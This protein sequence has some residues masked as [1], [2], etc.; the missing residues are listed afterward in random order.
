MNHHHYHHHPNHHHHYH[1]AFMHTSS[2][3]VEAEDRRDTWMDDAETCLRCI[4]PSCLSACL[5]CSV[6]PTDTS[7]TYTHSQ[8]HT[9]ASLS[10]THLL[11]HSLTYSLSHDPPSIGTARAI[12]S[13]AL[14][15]FPT[16]KQL[17]HQ[18]AVL[19]VLY[20]CMYRLMDVCMCRWI[21]G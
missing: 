7:Y 9:H 3:G 1:H 14:S 19:E 5:P 6:S 2:I 21:D 10:L 17:W 4:P 8:S 20:T 18:A 16:K 15:V 13:H 12:L 11:I